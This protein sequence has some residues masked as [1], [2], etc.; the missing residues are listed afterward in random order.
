MVVPWRSQP[1][2]AGSAVAVA[3]NTKGTTARNAR[4]FFAATF[5]WTW[6]CYAPLALG[7]HNPYEMPW[8]VLL[9]AGGMGPSLVGVVMMLLTYDRAG[10][11][12]FWRRCFSPRRVGGPWWAV[13]VFLFPIIWAASIALDLAWGGSPPGLKQLTDLLAQP[14]MWPLAAFISLMSGPWSE[15]FGWRGFALDP[16]LRR[17]GPL[18]GSLLLGA[19]W[20]IW[21]LPLYFMPGTWHAGMGLRLAGFWT[22]VLMNMGLALVMT[23]VYLGTGR[24]ILTGLLLHFTANFTGQLVAPVSDRV[25]VTRSILILAV[26]FAACAMLEWRARRAQP[27]LSASG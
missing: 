21:H 13:I 3:A 11:R 27:D 5:A 10:R 26:G 25:E 18:R 2:D 15:E 7:G 16:L 24:S 12:D 8:M 4:I 9:I 14:G 20:G 23:W 6:A 17:F 19:L 1:A 22:F